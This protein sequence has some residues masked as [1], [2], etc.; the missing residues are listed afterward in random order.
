LH[1]VS[2]KARAEMQKLTVE[3]LACID[4]AVIPLNNGELIPVQALVSRQSPLILLVGA[5]QAI[6]V[7]FAEGIAA[8][9]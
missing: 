7:L 9:A 4:V 1:A 6:W 3:N 2:E 8:M 5:M